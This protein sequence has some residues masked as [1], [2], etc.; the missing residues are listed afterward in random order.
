MVGSEMKYLNICIYC[1]TAFSVA[2]DEHIIPNFLGGK[3]KSF[4]IVCDKCN[5]IFGR[6][7]E[8]EISKQLN[9]LR[10]IFGLLSSRGRKAPPVKKIKL[11]DGRTVNLIHGGKPVFPVPIIEKKLLPDGTIQIKA[12]AGSE[13]QFKQITEGLKRKGDIKDITKVKGQE[14]IKE[15]LTFNLSVGGL[16]FFEPLRK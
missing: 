6:T 11:K 12:F 2:C 13:K 10:V 3:K 5:D 7:I 8:V 14:Y 4:N 9:T 16:D 15:Y 1:K